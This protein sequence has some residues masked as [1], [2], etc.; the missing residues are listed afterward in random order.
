MK[1]NNPPIGLILLANMNV[2]LFFFALII[3]FTWREAALGVLCVD[4]ALF[5]SWSTFYVIEAMEHPDTSPEEGWVGIEVQSW[6]M[7]NTAPPDHPPAR[8]HDGEDILE[9][10]AEEVERRNKA[11]KPLKPGEPGL[12]INDNKNN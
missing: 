8:L 2:G 12:E 1:T 9:D 5:L 4:A 7:E 6:D 11:L 3:G 10:A